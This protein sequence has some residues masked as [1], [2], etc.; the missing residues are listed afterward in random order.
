MFGRVMTLSDDEPQGNQVFSQMNRCI[1]EVVNPKRACILMTG[2]A[3][4]FCVN[5]TADDPAEIIACGKNVHSQFGP[6]AVNCVFLVNG[7]VVGGPSCSIVDIQC[8]LGH[9]TTLGGP[10]V[11]T[12]VK[13]KLGLQQTPLGE[14]CDG[15]WQGDDFIKLRAPGQPG[16]LPDQR[17]HS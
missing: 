11:G 7:S 13:L 14:A 16:D 2:L 17:V 8:I 5:I 12:I 9:G 6:L 15:F 1:L 4:L 10:A 3:K